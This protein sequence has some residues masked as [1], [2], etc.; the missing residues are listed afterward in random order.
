MSKE[1]RNTEQEAVYMAAEVLGK[2]F[3]QRKDIFASQLEDGRYVAIKEPLTESC[4]GSLTP[5]FRHRET[6]VFDTPNSAAISRTVFSFLSAR[7]SRKD[8]S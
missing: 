4:Q 1:I 3:T 8:F 2:T 7:S 6:N 5:R